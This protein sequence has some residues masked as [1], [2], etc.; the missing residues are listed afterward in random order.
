MIKAGKIR[1]IAIAGRVLIPR[2]E[3]ER[4]TGVK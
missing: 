1:T 3:I 4:L 2:T